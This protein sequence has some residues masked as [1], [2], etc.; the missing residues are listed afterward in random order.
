MLDLEQM[1]QWWAYLS[2]CLSD[3]ILS[4]ECNAHWSIVV[5]AGYVLALLIFVF[6]GY[7]FF[8]ANREIRRNRRILGARDIA[9]IE[10]LVDEQVRTG[11]KG[12]VR[13][14]AGKY[15]KALENS[16]LVGW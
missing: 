12:F 2:F 16:D 8:K 1:G 3:G 7:C 13:E 9:A 4:K 14:L 6:A 10:K 11:G 15:R 5:L